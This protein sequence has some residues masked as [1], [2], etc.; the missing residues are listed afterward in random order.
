[1]HPHNEPDIFSLFRE[2]SIYDPQL[3]ASVVT[4]SSVTKSS[5]TTAYAQNDVVTDGNAKTM[6]FKDASPIPGGALD[7]F[8][9]YL[10]ST[11][12]PT[13]PG[14]FS[15]LLF[16]RPMSIAADNAAFAPTNEELRRLKGIIVFSQ[17]KKFSANTVYYPDNFGHCYVRLDPGYKDLFGVLITDA[18]YT[19]ASME[20]FRSVIMG[21]IMR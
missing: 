7:I 8:G 14:A 1:M 15:L 12:A 17:Y 20:S 19:P 4:S 11:N 13:T 18:A 21:D 16:D 9:A 2:P 6:I 5:G 3:V 10:F